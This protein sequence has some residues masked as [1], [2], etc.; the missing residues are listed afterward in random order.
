[1]SVQDGID[2]TPD[3]LAE[4]QEDRQVRV[5]LQVPPCNFRAGFVY[6]VSAGSKQ[7]S[8]NGKAQTLFSNFKSFW[9]MLSVVVVSF[10]S[11]R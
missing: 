2:D 7:L 10:W 9:F 5:K 8:N 4:D 1:M 6:F 3:L 11:E